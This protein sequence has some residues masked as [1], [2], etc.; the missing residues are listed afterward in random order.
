MARLYIY[1]GGVKHIIIRK[2]KNGNQKNTTRNTSTGT[3]VSYKHMKRRVE[4]R[5]D[6]HR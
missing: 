5:N 6:N 4:V 3:H 1:I 2:I